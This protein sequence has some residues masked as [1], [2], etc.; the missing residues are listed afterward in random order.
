M[1]DVAI[2]RSDA[3][4]RRAI[5]VAVAVLAFLRLAHVRLL[6][7]DED[8]HLAAALDILHG[9]VPYRDFW[10]DKPPLDAL[11]YLV[12][13]AHA[14]WPL[15]LLD[16]VY[17][18]IAAW[19]AFRLARELWGEAEG[20]IAALLLT[21][22]LAFYL[23][24]GVIPFAADALLLVPHLAAVL[25]AQRKA[26]V[27]SGV[28]AGIGF[29]VNAK[30]LFVLAACVVWAGF[31]A[32][33]ILAGFLAPV[34]FGLGLLGVM[35]AWRGYVE[36]VWQWGLIYAR[37]APSTSVLGTGLRRTFDWAGFHAALVLGSVMAL[38]RHW[39]L[40]AWIAFSFLSICVGGR[41]VPRYFL[42]LLPPLVVAGAH[43]LVVA[44]RR[45]GMRAV[46]VFGVLLAV[47]LV[48]FG[49]RYA[50]L[51]VDP[52]PRWADV[53]LDEDS[54]AIA[55]QIVTLKQ[56]GDS[57]FV[58]GYRPDVY[59]YARMT[60][61]GLFWD[62]QPLTGVPADRHLSVSTA[63]YG[64]PAAA[65]RMALIQSRPTFVVDGLGLL[66]PPLAPSAYQEV[67]TWLANYDEVGRTKLSVLYRLRRR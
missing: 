44:R 6:W 37:S 46:V 57:L 4:W 10:Y 43:G 32:F 28:W 31:G 51:A 67:R 56:D 50:Q 24:A 65:N 20:R 22:F 60:P 38:R 18:C 42:Q 19:L 13:G 17:V 52:E 61:P 49:P 15:R 53:G 48:R 64:G 63:V 27:W 2:T 47:P 30:G 36:Q 7:S 11:Y 66:N 55:G 1:N 33:W 3:G 5:P 9:K 12:I 34:A 41:F 26:F 58:W 62:S 45:F 39:R 59:V 8:Y 16:G 25:Y 23:P 54:R 40:A 29:L 14:G 35:G 21:F